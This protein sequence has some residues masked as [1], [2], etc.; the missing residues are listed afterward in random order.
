MRLQEKNP[1]EAMKVFRYNAERNGDVWPVHV[2]LARVYAASGDLPKA[3]E[4]AQKALG[5]APDSLNR[6]NLES[7]IKSFSDGKNIEQ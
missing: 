7:M 5:Q 1:A 6:M 3:L 4:H 2:G